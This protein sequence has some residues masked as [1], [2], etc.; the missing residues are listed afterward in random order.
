MQVEYEVKLSRR[1][2]EMGVFTKREISK[3][4]LVW[5]YADANKKQYSEA[6]VKHLEIN[7]P[8]AFSELDFT[9]FFSPD[10]RLIDLRDDDGRFFNHSTKPN[11]GLG[12]VLA[13]VVAQRTSSISSFAGSSSS[14]SSLGGDGGGAAAG[15]AAAGRAAGAASAGAGASAGQSDSYGAD[16]LYALRDIK[17]GT[18]LLEDYNTYG[19]DPEWYRRLTM[20]RL[21]WI[22]EAA[23][24]MQGL[25]ELRLTITKERKPG[26]AKLPGSRRT[27]VTSPIDPEEGWFGSQFY[28]EVQAYILE[29]VPWVDLLRAVSQSSKMLHELV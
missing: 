18:E 12:S 25:D 4:T 10:G 26:V 20:E 22:D 16:D 27:S 17:A 11:L 19:E 8:K 29:F 28:I 21:K 6:E 14:S 15:R 13:E 24:L 23:V 9:S 7:D 2:G 3:D 1:T 5:K